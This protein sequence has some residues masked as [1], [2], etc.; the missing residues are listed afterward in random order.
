VLGRPGGSVGD[1]VLA[2]YGI[3]DCLMV[4]TEVAVDMVD[5]VD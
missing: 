3:S 1:V 2:V 4:L 5:I